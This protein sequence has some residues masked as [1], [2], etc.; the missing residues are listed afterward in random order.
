ML[1]C[2]LTAALALGC[3]D[4]RA[5]SED[6]RP[7]PVVEHDDEP[8][9]RPK[10]VVLIVV[11]QMRFDAFDRFG[12]QWQHGFAR[13]REQGR[14]FTAAYHEHALTETAPGH[15]TLATGCD[16]ARHGIVANGWLDRTS[17][18]KVE[19]VGDPAATI[20]GNEAAPGASSATLLCES[21]GDWMQAAN[22]ESVVIAMA[23]KDRAAI[24]L[25]GKRPDA[26][27]WYDD[28]FGGFT[29]SS[30]YTDARP[31][32]VDAYNGKDRAQALYGEGWT[33]SRP[34]R[35]YGDSRRTTAPE[36]V[37]TFSNYALTKQFPHVIEKPDRAPRN[38][39]RDTP[40]AD[41]MTLEL[42]REAIVGERMGADAVP[43]LLLIGL[44]GGD[45]AGHRYGPDSV[46]THD[47]YLRID[48]ALGALLD[49]L[50]A[51]IGEEHYVVILTSDHGVAPMPE[52]SDIE[53]AGRFDAKQQVA[54]LIERAA[55]EAGLAT[56]PRFQVSHGVELMFDASVAEVDRAKVRAR[57]AELLR[58]QQGVADVWTRDELL[59]GTNRSEFAEDWRRS[60]HPERSSDLLIQLAPG[61]VTYAEGTGHGTP[62]EYDQHVPL[63]IRGPGW[64]GVDERRIAT[65]DVAPTIATMVGVPI[66]DGI[67]GRAI[68]PAHTANR[69]R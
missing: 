6:G 28:E 62:Y 38:V 10:L 56:P 44:S 69:G 12:A 47:Y 32:W 36:L 19:A 25:G 68:S 27:L 29:T 26:V 60:F 7:A 59:A 63:A 61:V 35:E 8:P 1:P 46:E 55:T 41:Q 17:G 57:L 37:A 50:D 14:Y 2:L 20:L 65:V 13:V 52:Y 67:D 11:D 53:G 39:V 34:D 30:E 43:D 49:D 48:A 4:R 5:P 21:V 23:V 33:L 40:F 15:A 9:A 22:P 24:L 45:Y 31:A 64:A 51:K 54:A 58:E 66:A 18:A 3:Q 16:P 42:A